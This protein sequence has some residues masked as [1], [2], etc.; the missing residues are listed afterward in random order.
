MLLASDSKVAEAADDAVS[1]QLQLAELEK[2]CPELAM[3][4]SEFE[5]ASNPCLAC[6]RPKLQT[7]SPKNTPTTF[8][9]EELSHTDGFANDASWW[10]HIEARFGL[11]CLLLRLEDGRQHCEIYETI[12][13]TSSYHA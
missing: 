4:V 7:N 9:S 10:R 1:V 2:S 3:V 8:D 11:R 13:L 6:T 5:E 12:R